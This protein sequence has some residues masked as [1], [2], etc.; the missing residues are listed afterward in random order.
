MFTEWEVPSM[1]ILTALRSQ[2]KTMPITDVNLAKDIALNEAGGGMMKFIGAQSPYDEGVA[3]ATEAGRAVV[4]MQNPAF[5]AFPV[6]PVLR[7][8]LLSAWKQ[9]YKSDAPKEIQDAC[10]G[11]C[12]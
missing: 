9:V 7:N 5:L 11:V 12:K 10:A 8:N 6:V 2:N 4:G 1:G 3:E